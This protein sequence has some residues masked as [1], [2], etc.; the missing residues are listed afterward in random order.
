MG[1]LSRVGFGDDDDVERRRQSQAP[2]SKELTD[3][4]LH[5]VPHHG[6]ADTRA[7]RDAEPR[8]GTGGRRL[9]DDEARG[10]AST[11]LTLQRQE[12]PP[13][14]QADSLGVRSGAGHG[15][16][17]SS[18]GLLRWDGDGQ[19]FA[20]LGAAPLQHLSTHWRGHATAKPVCARPSTVARL[21][22]PLHRKPHHKPRTPW[23]VNLRRACLG[24]RRTTRRPGSWLDA[25]RVGAPASPAEPVRR[26]DQSSS[27][28]RGRADRSTTAWAGS[29]PSYRT[30]NICSVIGI[31]TVTL[32]ARLLIDTVL[33]TPS[34][35]SLM[36]ARISCTFS[37]LPNRSPTV[38][39]RDR[40]PVQ[41]STRSPRQESP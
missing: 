18:A 37:P 21:I 1:D 16:A 27:G 29:F 10:V 32:C 33:R 40:S 9:H 2:L 12:L 8:R 19:P 34:A 3:E 6:V 28:L 13:P 24:G 5:A 36:L 4:P 26:L 14:P 22:G 38:R 41:V 7:D 11:T 17:V 15:S 31:S 35:T 39:L 25:T 20:P 30:A 23:K